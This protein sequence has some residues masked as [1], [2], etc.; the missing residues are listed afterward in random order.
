MGQIKDW[1]FM[2]DERRALREAWESGD[3]LAKTVAVFQFEKRRQEL[4]EGPLWY[5]RNNLRVALES[6]TEVDIENALAT[7]KVARTC[8]AVW[9]Y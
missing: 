6:G 3:E 7:L 9:D 8:V 1:G 2:R 5:V 4:D